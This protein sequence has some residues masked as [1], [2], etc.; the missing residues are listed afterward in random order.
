VSI[1][2]ERF[3][4]RFAAEKIGRK[5]LVRALKKFRVDNIPLMEFTL[6]A[7]FVF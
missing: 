7:L 6:R 3:V 5:Y 1:R 4:D 2:D